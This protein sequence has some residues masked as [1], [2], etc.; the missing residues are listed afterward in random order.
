MLAIAQ[1]KYARA[2]RGTTGRFRPCLAGA[3]DLPLA[4]E[5]FDVVLS[6][7]VLRNLYA[8]IDRILAGVF[9]S[10]VPGGSVSFLDL[11]EP[12]HPLLR[13]GFRWYMMTLVGLYGATLFGADYPIPYLPDSARRFMK[14]NEFPSALQ[15]AGF[16]RVRARPFMLGTVT[17]YSGTRPA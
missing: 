9:A 6:G 7:F 10:L 3:E 12:T 2:R 14:A 15:R 1:R 4:D 17:L 16:Q 5:R 13:R 8:R 11:T